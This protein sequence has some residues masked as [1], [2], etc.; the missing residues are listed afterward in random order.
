MLS[1]CGNCVRRGRCAIEDLPVC[2]KRSIGGSALTPPSSSHSC[3]HLHMGRCSENTAAVAQP[4]ASSVPALAESQY[5][6]VFLHP[7]PPLVFFNTLLG[8]SLLTRS[9]SRGS[10]ESYFPLTEQF[11][12]QSSPPSCGPATLAMVLNSLRID[13]GKVWALPWRWFTEDMLAACIRPGS[14][15]TTMEHFALMAECNG[16]TAQTFYAELAHLHFFRTL[17]RTVTRSD[18]QRIVVCFDREGLGQTGTGHYSPVAAYD[19][20]ADMVL[21]LDV[22]RFK[23]PPYW[24]PVKDLFVAMTTRDPVT[25]KSRGFF[26]VQSGQDS[27][28]SDDTYESKNCND[29]VVSESSTV[30]E[31]SDIPDK[32]KNIVSSHLSALDGQIITIVESV[33]LNQESENLKTITS[34][35]IHS[36]RLRA[37]YPESNELLQS[38]LAQI[39]GTQ[40]YKIFHNMTISSHT[41]DCDER[42]S[43]DKSCV[44]ELSLA[45]PANCVSAL[46]NVGLNRPIDLLLRSM[47]QSAAEL[48]ALLIIERGHEFLPPEDYCRLISLLAV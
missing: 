32:E 44:K 33:F 38:A 19:E 15:G 28:G 27:P 3:K 11:L 21:I 8:R 9:I 40:L 24:V 37:L 29:S 48:S 23:Y 13:P 17:V 41:Y 12:T 30:A 1:Q 42:C 39:K 43:E 20:V 26:V 25:N 18:H 36:V 16:A 14:D 47:P 6:G 31:I 2:L 22:A 5:M 46:I 34:E 45:S 4:A 7:S 10:A 35:F